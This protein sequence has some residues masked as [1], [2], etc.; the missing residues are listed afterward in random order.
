MKAT[1]STLREWIGFLLVTAAVLIGWLLVL[2]QAMRYA[3]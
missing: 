2:Y 3:A 1:R